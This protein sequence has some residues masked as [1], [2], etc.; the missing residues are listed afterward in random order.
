[1]IKFRYFS[2]DLHF[3]RLQFDGVVFTLFY[4]N[5][6]RME[7]QVR[8]VYSIYV[9]I[10]IMILIYWYLIYVFHFYVSSMV[11][12]IYIFETYTIISLF[13]WYVTQYSTNRWAGPFSVSELISCDR[14]TDTTRVIR[15]YGFRFF[16][17]A[18][19]TLKFRMF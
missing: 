1:M 7:P 18:Y 16:K 13:I 3:S 4:R 12:K 5:N 9:W 19:E 8:S 17:P 14:R 10:I 2:T 15:Y 6:F 11:E